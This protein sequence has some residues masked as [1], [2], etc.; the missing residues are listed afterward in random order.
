MQPSHEDTSNLMQTLISNQA[1]SSKRVFTLI[2]EQQ[3]ISRRTSR[4]LWSGLAAT[5]LV[6]VLLLF[7]V[8]RISIGSAPLPGSVQTESGRMERMEQSF[9]LMTQNLEEIQAAML[10]INGYMQAIS[11]DIGR[12]HEA[13]SP[14]LSMKKIVRPKRLNQMGMRKLLKKSQLAT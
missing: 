8:Y 12:L 4:F 11:H 6:S 9:I 14:L 5:F 3:R 13:D 10:S 2:E 7:F 1:E